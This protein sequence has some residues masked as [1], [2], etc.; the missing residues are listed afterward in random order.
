MKTSL[1]ET[2]KDAGNI[3][4]EQVIRT[5]S[6]HITGLVEAIAAQIHSDWQLQTARSQVFDGKPI[7]LL[8][9]PVIEQGQIKSATAVYLMKFPNDEALTGV[10]ILSML[11]F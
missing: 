8:A 4:I 10:L 9:K 5:S 6:K 2:H 7:S 1:I 3:L 11:M